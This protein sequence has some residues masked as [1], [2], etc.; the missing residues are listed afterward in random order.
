MWEFLCQRHGD[1][2]LL[3]AS[4]VLSIWGF[5]N[6]FCYHTTVLVTVAIVEAIAVIVIT[7]TEQS[8]CSKQSQSPPWSLCCGRWALAEDSSERI[9]YCEERELALGKRHFPHQECQERLPVEQM[10]DWRWME[11][12]ALIHYKII[13]TESASSLAIS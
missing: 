1:H 3:T 5:S 8:P 11:G 9:V 4:G 13:N 2:S 10:T 7:A 6:P 12:E